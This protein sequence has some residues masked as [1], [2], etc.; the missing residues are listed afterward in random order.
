MPSID[1]FYSY[2]SADVQVFLVATRIIQKK[3][4]VYKC[5]Q[6]CGDIYNQ[7]GDHTPVKT[8][9]EK[10]QSFTIWPHLLILI[11]SPHR[12]PLQTIVK[13]RA[14]LKSSGNL[15]VWASIAYSACRCN[16]QVAQNVWSYSVA[17]YQ[18][19][20]LQNKSKGIVLQ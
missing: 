17:G 8:L 4:A 16:V 6:G 20:K 3:T 9:D 7:C 11:T 19:L 5:W 2:N 15:M 1:F 18:Q 13:E 14:V 12:L 10:D